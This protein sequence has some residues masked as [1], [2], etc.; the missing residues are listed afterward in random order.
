MLSASVPVVLP[1]QHV[2]ARSPILRFF[3]QLQPTPETIILMSAVVIGIG[4][5]VGVILFRSLISL[6]HHWMFEGLMSQIYQLGAWTLACVPTLG[7]VLVAL[8]RWGLKD[9]GGGMSS[10]ISAVQSGKEF[11]PLKP[12]MKAIAAAISLGSGASLGPEGPS[13][14][15]GANFGILLGQFFRVSEERQQLLLGAGAA[16]GLAAG[17]NAPIAGVFFA[18]EVVLGS[19][20]QTSKA[21]VVVLSSVVAGLVVQMGMGTQAAFDLPVYEVR[22]PLELPLYLGLGLCACVVSI[23]Y[24]NLLKWMKSFFQGEVPYF[25]WM[26]KIPSEVHPVLGG[27]CV[28]LVALVLPQILGVGYDTIEAVLRDVK[29]PLLLLFTLLGAKLLLT[30][31]SLG[32]GLVGGIFAPAMFLGAAL[33]AAYGEMLPHL[34]PMFADN[35]AAAPAYAMVG[36]A[37]VLASTVRAP[38]TATLLLFEMTRDYRIV[39]PLMAAVGLSV[40]LVEPL[41][42]QPIKLPIERR[43]QP[44][45]IEE[46]PA[47][48]PLELRAADRKQE[49]LK[50]IAVSEA[51]ETDFL[52]L[53]DSLPVL[54]AGLELIQHQRH[55]A[56]VMTDNN[57]L[58]GIITVHDINRAIA[59]WEKLD[60][61]AVMTYTLGDVCTTEMLYAYMDERLS[62]AVERMST[63]GLHQLPVLDR[64]NAH[65]VVGLLT[66]EGINLACDLELTHANLTPYLTQPELELLTVAAGPDASEHHQ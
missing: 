61:S 42:S 23:A 60:T 45:P 62:E 24:T 6:I 48:D 50:T 1:E 40:W 32:S 64:D 13:V 37:A 20:F 49:I 7:G 15:I 21:S 39:L 3:N 19:T 55:S 47:V 17:F 16:A 53:S 2:P 34:F 57:E 9:L 11:S 28:G 56:L 63:R 4:A 58:I 51:M 38:L 5:G 27:L 31:V 14:E 33:G 26:S 65:E 43:E 22:S 12:V 59:R 8:I 25:T 10:L 44:E 66:K 18:L 52:E 35:I 29:F 36:M 30:A 46:K 54:D 41:K